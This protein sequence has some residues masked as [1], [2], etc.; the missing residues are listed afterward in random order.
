MQHF[1]SSSLHNNLHLWFLRK[2]LIPMMLL[3]CE[4]LIYNS[5]LYFI[6]HVSKGVWSTNFLSYYIIIFSQKSESNKKNRVFF[7]VRIS[8]LLNSDWDLGW[9]KHL[10]IWSLSLGSTER[11]GI[12]LWGEHPLRRRV[13]VSVLPDRRGGKINRCLLYL[14]SGEICYSALSPTSSAVWMMNKLPLRVT[15][16]VFVSLCVCLCVI[17]VSTYTYLHAT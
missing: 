4:M 11:R 7:S 12:T 8:L 10:T 1:F 5:G 14:S 15:A 6:K 16:F 3:Q 2:K 13:A 17:T 9:I